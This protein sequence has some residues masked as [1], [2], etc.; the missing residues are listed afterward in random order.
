MLAAARAHARPAHMCRPPL[1]AHLHRSCWCSLSCRPLPRL[2]RRRTRAGGSPASA[3]RRCRMRCWARCARCARVRTLPCACT[4]CVR[5]FGCPLLPITSRLERLH[6]RTHARAELAQHPRSAHAAPPAAPHPHPS[7]PPSR[8]RP[9]H[10][11]SLPQVLALVPT[12]PAALLPLVVQHMPH[13]LRD[14]PTQCLFLRGLFAV[15]EVMKSTRLST[16]I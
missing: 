10:C 3:R 16:S 11:P 9:P 14:R 13:K 15:A 1:P 12:A 2:R 8:P 7:H 5:S 4:L 6:A